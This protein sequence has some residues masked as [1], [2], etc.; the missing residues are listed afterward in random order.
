M[1]NA[2]TKKK[3]LATAKSYLKSGTNLQ[4]AEEL[5]S[6]LLKDSANRQESKIWVVLFDAVK[7]QYEQ[8]NEQLYL[9]QQSDTSNLFVSARKMFLVAEGLD[10]LE[11]TPGKNGKVKLKYRGKN[12]GLLDAY[13]A[14]LYNGGVFFLG[15]QKYQEA[16]DFFDT[17]IDC[18]KQPL[19]SSYDYLNKDKR[20]PR[21][22]SFAVYCGYKQKNAAL[23]LKHSQLALRDTAA[24]EK[25]YKYLAETYEANG[26]TA[27]YLSTLE[28]GFKLY[29]KSSY[30]FPYLFDFHYRKGD[31]DASLKL[32]DK[33]LKADSINQ[34][35]M[36]A[37][38]SVLLCLENFDECIAQCDRLI[39]L[40]D[41]FADAYLN[42][43]L[44]YFNQAAKMDGDASLSRKYH[45]KI[46]A[47]YKKAMPYMQHYRSLVPDAKDKWA[48]PLYTI[49]LN[50]NMGKEFDE[51]DS[52]LKM[53]SK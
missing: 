40:N 9:K 31:Y 13:R 51:I 16:F 5:M 19:F 7:K 43:G 4:K 15:K 23:T 45:S 48:L 53:K 39:A 3:D 44:A 33:A 26:D 29:P 32:C 8:V 1:L 28:K 6:N 50:L 10:S 24:L 36:F 25:V 2:Q 21:A 37:R 18:A 20:L 34:V 52:M 30:F 38:S 35:A 27:I 41:K 17:Y 11:N 14:N 47:L 12:S 22:A 46:L 49:Y 42:A